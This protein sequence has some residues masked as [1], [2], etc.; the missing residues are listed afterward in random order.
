MM[1]QIPDYVNK[2]SA[3]HEP[4]HSEMLRFMLDA[5]TQS[6]SIRGSTMRKANSFSFTILVLIGLFLGPVRAQVA[7]ELEADAIKQDVS[8]LYSTTSN[9]ISVKLRSGVKIMGY[10]DAVGSDTFTLRDNGSRRTIRYADVAS[11]SRTGLSKNQK[12]ALLICAGAAVVVVVA[13]FGRKKRS[14]G[15]NPPCLLC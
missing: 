3:H 11:V 12:T 15:F 8:R 6:F 14:G 10:I 7:S 4:I 9:K 5:T 1:V 13:V 2:F